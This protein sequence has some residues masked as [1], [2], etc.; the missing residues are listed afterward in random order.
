MHHIDAHLLFVHEFFE[1]VHVLL[2]LTH[3]CHQVLVADAVFHVL[4]ILRVFDVELGVRR[5]RVS[6]YKVG[7]CQ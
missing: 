7:M 3:E 2:A 4:G 6:E 5:V 1:E